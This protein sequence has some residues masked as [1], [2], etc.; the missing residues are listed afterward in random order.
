MD[1][2]YITRWVL[3]GDPCKEGKEALR[4]VEAAVNYLAN[5]N[6]EAALECF[7]EAFSLT[8]FEQTQKLKWLD[9][10]SEKA[11]AARQSEVQP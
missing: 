3:E 11:G 5:D 1:I 10:L 8:S 9:Y 7:R 6:D 2:N 4:L